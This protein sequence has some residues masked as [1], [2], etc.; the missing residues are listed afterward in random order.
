MGKKVQI[1][2]KRKNI[3]KYLIAQNK[4]TALGEKEAFTGG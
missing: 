4:P 2:S 3:Y 1:I